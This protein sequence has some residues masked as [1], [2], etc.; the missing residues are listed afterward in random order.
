MPYFL[1]RIFLLLYDI[2]VIFVQPCHLASLLHN[3]KLCCCGF[4]NELKFSIRRYRVTFISKKKTKYH[5]FHK[6]TCRYSKFPSS[7]HN[8]KS[9]CNF[10]L[11]SLGDSW[12]YFHANW[13]LAVHTHMRMT[14]Y[15]KLSSTTTLLQCSFKSVLQIRNLLNL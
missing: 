9:E 8:V 15:K 7:W 14:W 12:M 3:L 2:F 5:N 6:R 1:S 11:I 4:H 10:E 13:M